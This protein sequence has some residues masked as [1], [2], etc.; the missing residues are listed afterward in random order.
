[1]ERYIFQQKILRFKL[2]SINKQKR[3]VI[4]ITCS[5]SLFLCILFCTFLGKTEMVLLLQSSKATTGQVSCKSNNQDF[6]N[7]RSISFAIKPQTYQTVRIV[8]PHQINQVSSF[9]LIL[10][11]ETDNN[12]IIHYLQLK[13][14]GFKPIS[15]DL[16][17]L[18][19]SQSISDSQL[20]NVLSFS[21]INDSPFLEFEKPTAKFRPDWLMIIFYL[22]I[23]ISI[24][25]LAIYSQAIFKIK[26]DIKN[27]A[28]AFCFLIVALL[29]LSM[30]LKAGFNASPDERDHFMTAE[31]Y[32]THT[33]TPVR[34][35]ELGVYTYNGLWAYS[36][37]YLKSV[38]YLLA[39]RFS[40]LFDNTF[41]SYKSVRFFGVLML[42][43]F[44]LLAI[45][46]PK[47]NL[48]LLP[49]LMTPQV[50]YLFSYINDSS[51]PIFLSCLLLIITEYFKDKIIKLKISKENIV[52]ILIVGF[53]LGILA[54][55]KENYLVFV[56]F[57]IFYLFSLPVEF[58]GNFKSVIQNTLASLKIHFKTPLLIIGLA[59]L[60]MGGREL[61]IERQKETPLSIETAQY[62]NQSKV[63]FENH[64]ASGISGKA[65]FGSYQKMLIPW[66]L[67][68]VR[69]FISSYGY[70]KYWGSNLF[71][72]VNYILF[73]L[74]IAGFIVFIFKNYRL[75]TT[76]WAIVCLIFI[77]AIIFASSYLYSYRY[78]YQAQGKYL[79]PILPIIG[80]L[81][82]KVQLNSGERFIK[83]VVLPLSAILFFLGIYSF[84]CIGLAS[85]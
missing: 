58:K 83:S 84:I 9:R 71:Y 51:F 69:S 74:M 65:R 49:I 67:T 26:F 5:L 75:E 22:V 24:S 42:A 70:M 56:L 80:F 61:T 72:K 30:A 79:F 66:M 39:G 31:Y 13:K 64:I 45:R 2:P 33:E 73:A 36:R 34:N 50:W 25:F 12:L 63:N 8:L 43:F 28:Y 85:I 52:H 57:F 7:S 54:L 44:A 3:L 1:M 55:S 68:S 19:A 14:S 32:K 35:A 29:G 77:L 20:T 23:S 17:T 81:I 16:K 11:S 41:E 10:G 6:D 4:S 38:D 82:Y 59:L 18:K 37:V 15:I 48:I 46:F 60:V 78:D 21:T 62:Y 40:N 76:L 47:Q 27:F 53:L